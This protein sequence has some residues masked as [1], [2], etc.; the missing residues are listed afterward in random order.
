MWVCKISHRQNGNHYFVV[1]CALLVLLVV[2]TLPYNVVVVW[3]GGKTRERERFKVTTNNNNNQKVIIFYCM[4]NT[5]ITNHDDDAVEYNY[6][7]KY[8]YTK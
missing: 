7:L 5:N 4:T 1:S 8:T 3:C 2:Q 6:L